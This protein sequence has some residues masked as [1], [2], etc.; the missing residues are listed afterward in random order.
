MS[1]NVNHPRHYTQC[2]A[3]LEPIDVIDTAPFNLG[4]AIKYVCRAGH[5]DDELQDLRKAKWYI[6]RSAV[7][8]TF[9]P[10]PYDYFIKTS[11]FL[12]RKLEPFAKFGST[13]AENLI[14]ELEWLIDS[15]IEALINERYANK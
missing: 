9:N 13:T 4:N 1:D 3:T 2:G 5:K 10:E 6:V 12:M 8:C 11:G 14:I 15:K 7:H